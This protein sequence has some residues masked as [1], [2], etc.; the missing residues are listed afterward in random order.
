LT[1]LAPSQSLFA[2]FFARRFTFFSRKAAFPFAFSLPVAVSGVAFV[3]AGL[4]VVLTIFP[5]RSAKK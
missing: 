2:F 1:F 3:F 4:V 5:P